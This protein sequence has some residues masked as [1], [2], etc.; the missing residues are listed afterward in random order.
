MNKK[1]PVDKKA[2][3]TLQLPAFPLLLVSPLAHLVE[4]VEVALVLGLGRETHLP[5][6]KKKHTKRKAK[7][8]KKN[9]QIK[10]QMCTR[11]HTRNKNEKHGTKLPGIRPNQDHKQRKQSVF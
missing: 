7:N 3:L 10:K 2:S 6:T 11:K 8:G 5:K 9:G 1:L 4:D